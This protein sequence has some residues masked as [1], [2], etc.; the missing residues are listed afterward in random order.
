MINLRDHE[1]D[2]KLINSHI[3]NTMHIPMYCVHI[4]L[5]QLN[6]A[7]QACEI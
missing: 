6:I 5:T 3:T 2:A 4:E 1:K 7:S